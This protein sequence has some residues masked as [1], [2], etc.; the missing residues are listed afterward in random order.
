MILLVIAGRI[1]DRIKSK[2]IGNL[3]ALM[4]LLELPLLFA[5]LIS[6]ITGRKYLACGIISMCFVMQIILNIV[7]FIKFKDNAKKD[8]DFVVWS[9]TFRKTTRV[10]TILSLL[11]NFKF[12]K[13]FYTGFFGLDNFMAVFTKPRT[14]ISRPV[15]IITYVSWVFIYIPIFASDIIVFATTRWGF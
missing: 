14:T 5:L 13:F 3:I 15:K 8:A 6:S 12:L 1:R 10:V 2:I 11:L 7:T 9:R 4:S